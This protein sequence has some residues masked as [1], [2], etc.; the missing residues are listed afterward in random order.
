ML[1]FAYGSNLWREQMSRRC[2][3]SREVGPGCLAGWRWIITTRGYASVVESPADHV[4]GTV[5][6]LSERDVREL[7]RFEGVASGS[8]RKE[9]LMVSCRGEEQECLVYVDPVTEEGQPKKEYFDRINAG[10]SDAAL[11]GEYLRRYIRPFV[12]PPAEKR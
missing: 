8:Y 9:L 5:Y 4:L 2:S 3:E 11:P 10:I 7:D 12:P 1:Y 6:D